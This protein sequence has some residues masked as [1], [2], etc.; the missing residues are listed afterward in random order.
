[1]FAPVVISVNGLTADELSPELCPDGLLA[2]KLY[3]VGKG[4]NVLG[5]RVFSWLYFL[6]ADKKCNAKDQEK[7]TLSIANKK[8]MK[9]NDDVLIPFIEQVR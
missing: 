9:Y 7:A 3:G 4:G 5:N 1:M 6:R 2:T 8:F